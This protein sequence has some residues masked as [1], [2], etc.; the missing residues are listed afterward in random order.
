MVSA[1]STIA[2]LAVLF[3]LGGI[4]FF[5]ITRGQVNDALVQLSGARDADPLA[6]A[7]ASAT[8]VGELRSC[9]NAPR[10]VELVRAK[11]VRTVGGIGHWR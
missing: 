4:V 2:A 5:F 10:L 8:T 9:P 7:I 11:A 1:Q 6:E 3:V